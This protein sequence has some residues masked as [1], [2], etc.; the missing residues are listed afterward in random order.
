M[1]FFYR[2]RHTIIAI[3]I[4][5]GLFS[6]ALNVQ[7]YQRWQAAQQQIASFEASSLYYAQLADGYEWIYNQTYSKLTNEERQS[8][9]DFLHYLKESR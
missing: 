9:D 1:K 6:V 2:H 7:F 8:Y 4:I 5:L 3:C